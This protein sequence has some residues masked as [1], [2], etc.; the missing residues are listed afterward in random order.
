MTTGPEAEEAL[1]G[2]LAGHV[3]RLAAPLRIDR[4]GAGQSNITSVVTD[5][6][7]RQWILRC[8]P[9]GA[10]AGAHDVH[11]EVR[12]LRALAGTSVP[13]PVVVAA[14]AD[15][16]GIGG[17]FC[18]MERVRGVALADERDAGALSPQERGRLSVETVEV[19]ARIHDLDPDS[20]GLGNLGRRD[21]YLDR[22]IDRTRRNWEAWG[23][24]SA[25]AG[26]WRE[27]LR[28]LTGAVPRQQRVVIAHGDYR[29]SNLLVEDGGITAV[30]DWELCTLGDPLADLAW[31]VDDWRSPGDPA[32]TMPSPTRVG[33]FASRERLIADYAARTGLDVGGLG[34]YRAFTHWKAATLLQGV[35][36]RRRSGSLGDHGALD[37]IDL[38]HTIAYLL[39]AALAH[40]RS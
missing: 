21:G 37:L 10:P 19:L 18:V 35:L 23:G 28:R 12:I 16:A 39:D 1:A 26:A 34:Y 40:V 31:L 36:L 5:A 20:V 27:C 14:G 30:L 15:A 9:P 7:G 38:E 2:W 33:G 6:E 22:Q 4:L 32:I 3:E 25:A 11:R 17:A 29:L 8:P 24:G 13:V